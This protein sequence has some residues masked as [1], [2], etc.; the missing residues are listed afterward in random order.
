M[1]LLSERQLC[2]VIVIE[3]L[4]PRT[5]RI[6]NARRVCCV[7]EIFPQ[8]GMYQRQFRVKFRITVA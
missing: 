7:E 1:G 8:T 4:L 5:A 3:P 6:E 2:D